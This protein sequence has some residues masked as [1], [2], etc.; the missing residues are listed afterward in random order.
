MI[1]LF[2]KY[3][4]FGMDVTINDLEEKVRLDKPL[5][6]GKFFQSL[7]GSLLWQ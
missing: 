7:D 6:F 2:L 4:P 3:A 5:I 1:I